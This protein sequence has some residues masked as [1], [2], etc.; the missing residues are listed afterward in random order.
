M[1]MPT[2]SFRWRKA[3]RLDTLAR[4]LGGTAELVIYP[5]ESHGFGSRLDTKNGADALARTLAFLG[6][7]LDAH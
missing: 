7:A 5:G 3:K 2:P 4:N 1:A 6:K